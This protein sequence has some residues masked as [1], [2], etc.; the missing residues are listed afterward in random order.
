MR[1]GLALYR[2]GTRLLSPFLGVIANR[3]VRAGKEAPDR[4]HQRYAKQLPERPSG[5]LI[6]FHAA[7]VGES[8]IQLELAAKIRTQ[9]PDTASLFTCQTLTGANAIAQRLASDPRFN[10]GWHLQQMAP[11]D[12]AAAAHR[13]VQHWRP[14]LAVFAEGEIWPNLLT[15]LSRSAIPAALINARMTEKSISG[16]QRWANTSRS[17]FGSFAVIL[18]SNQKTARALE[19]LSNHPV[20]CPG[21]LKSALP[22]PHVPPNDLARLS[23]VITGRPVLVAAS[24]HDG[25]E[26]LIIDAIR[27]ITP[28]PVTII[29]PRHSERGDRI[30]QL[31]RASGLS[32]ARR[33]QGE[34]ISAQTDILLADTMGEMGLWYRLADTVY[35]GGGH[36][37]GIGGHNP[38]EP[39]RLGKPVITGPSLFNFEEMAASLIQ[40][41]G[42]Q[43]VHTAG[44][45]ADVFPATPPSPALLAELES[46]AQG[47]MTATLAALEPYLSKLG[48]RS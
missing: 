1:L 18:A 35:L 30:E 22:V 46:E 6:W 29:A 37:P 12:T 24:T 10:D 38:L 25:E 43:I 39:L 4:L 48:S 13:F 16:W 28:R 3:R 32:H 19:D 20:P 15:Q 31:L 23:S 9:R 44:D 45:I 40:R 41:G 21:N 5:P 47:P 26:A 36:T 7:S 27:Q 34:E 11:F 2:L 8:L 42:L 17:I 14:G 33:S